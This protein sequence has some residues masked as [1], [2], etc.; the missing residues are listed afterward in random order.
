[1]EPME[2][3]RVRLILRVTPVP[4]LRRV[5]YE[6]SQEF[7]WDRL[8]LETGMAG[9]QEIDP[10]SVPR[11]V[12]ALTDFY[13]R[14]GYALVQITPEV[15]AERSQVRLHIQEGPLVRIG[16]VQFEGNHAFASWT[17]FNIGNDL[18]GELEA[19]QPKLARPCRRKASDSPG[20]L[21][22]F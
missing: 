11:V 10:E 3:G 6:G 22:L 12:N 8:Q 5:V 13:H 16:D 20:Q 4:T 17:L 18:E 7:E 9:A 21:T 1:M 15:E 2:D 19:G 14:E